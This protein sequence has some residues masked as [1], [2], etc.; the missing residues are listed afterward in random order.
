MNQQLIHFVGALMITIS[1]T[2]CQLPTIHEEAEN[3]SCAQ[4]KLL[5][6]KNLLPPT[7]EEQLDLREELYEIIFNTLNESRSDDS[8]TDQQLNPCYL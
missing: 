8:P 7:A 2:A 5:K 6:E 4:L 1:F 3:A